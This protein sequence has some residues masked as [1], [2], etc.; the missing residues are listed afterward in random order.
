MR[1]GPFCARS[2][3]YCIYRAQRCAGKWCS[4]GHPDWFGRS[5]R[6]H[7]HPAW[8]RLWGEPHLPMR[9]N[10]SARIRTVPRRCLRPTELRSRRSHRRPRG[11][12]SRVGQ[13]SLADSGAFDQATPTPPIPRRP[14]VDQDWDPGVEL[15]VERLGPASTIRGSSSVWQTLYC[16]ITSFAAGARR[17]R[18]DAP[19]ICR[20][21]RRSARTGERSFLATAR[22]A[23]RSPTATNSASVSSMQIQ[24]DL[25]RV[26]EAAERRL[27]DHT[28]RDRSR[29]PAGKDASG[30]EP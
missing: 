18:R 7:P 20:A 23:T 14:Q 5:R 13:M 3:S 25:E 29:P 16:G 1:T 6:W 11:A 19:R 17:S 22:G 9:Q 4:T 15:V 26:K 12:L 24:D 2:F 10:R 28:C 27:V 21:R 8:R 30:A